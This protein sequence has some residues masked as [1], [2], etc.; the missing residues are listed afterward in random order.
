MESILKTQRGICFW[1]GAYGPTHLHHIIHAGVSKK[2]QEK[3]GLVCYLCPFCHNDLHD[4]IPDEQGR[5]RDFVLKPLA[6][7]AWELK[8]IVEE[9][10]YHNHALEAAREEWM[11]QIGR[12]Y[13]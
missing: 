13:L 1:C 4:H 12:S 8:Y 5:D 9:Y 7:Q 2:T 11:R 6:Q 10:P 3:M